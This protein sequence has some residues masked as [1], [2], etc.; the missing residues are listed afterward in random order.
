MEEQE[1]SETIDNLDPQ[2]CNEFVSKNE[3][4]FNNLKNLIH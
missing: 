1:Y 3:W 4:T 2:K